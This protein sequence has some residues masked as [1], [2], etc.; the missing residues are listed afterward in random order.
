MNRTTTAAALALT[1]IALAG[2]DPCDFEC[3]VSSQ[4][5]G[6]AVYDVSSGAT[7]W[8]AY[9][10]RIDEAGQTP[11]LMYEDGTIT[12]LG[13]F[14]WGP[15]K[16]LEGTTIGIRL[17]QGADSPPFPQPGVINC[18]VIETSATVFWPDGSSEF[19]ELPDYGF[20]HEDPASLGFT[21][22][23]GATTYCASMVDDPT[24]HPKVVVEFC[25]RPC[26][27]NSQ[28]CQLVAWWMTRVVNPD[29][30]GP[31]GFG[32]PDGVI[33]VHDLIYVVCAHADVNCDGVVDADDIICVLLFWGQTMPDPCG[34]GNG[35]AT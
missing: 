14:E 7:L 12:E 5:V 25:G 20:G 17:L 34:D 6:F 19:V 18:N 30:S 23:D 21:Q 29:V 24:C 26:S 4:L 32:V 27:S 9:M 8:P 11:Y 13:G 2:G 33:D 1:S 22:T 3:N 10:L 16:V 35:D 15:P 28:A 31:E